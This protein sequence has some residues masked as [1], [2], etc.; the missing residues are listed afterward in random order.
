M[1]LKG[2][3]QI[4]HWNIRYFLNETADQGVIVSVS[5]AGSGVAMDASDNLAT[6]KAASSGALP[7]GVLLD[8]FVDI[9][10]TKFH[11]N[12]HKVQANKG[13]KATVA[14]KG[15]VVTDRVVSATAGKT[16]VLAS[17]GFVTNKADSGHDEAVNPTVG[18]FLTDKD[19]NGYATLYVDL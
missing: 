19:E 3:R 17:S 11:I 14:Q 10:Q 8:E 4:D 2:N 16:A 15:W 13:D 12:R 7:L 18:R 6:V 1:A 9:D 5:T